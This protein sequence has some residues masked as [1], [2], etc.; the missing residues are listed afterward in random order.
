[1]AAL[2]L[3]RSFWVEMELQ[4]SLGVLRREG[5]P[6]RERARLRAS[7]G[8]LA[9]RGTLNMGCLGHRALAFVERWVTSELA[10]YYDEEE[11][12]WGR[13]QKAPLG[14][15]N[16]WLLGRA[17]LT[18]SKNPEAESR[19]DVPGVALI[20]LAMGALALGIVQ[21]RDWGWTSQ[22]VLGSFA[23]AAASVVMFLW[24]LSAPAVVK[25]TAWFSALAAS[26][27]LLLASVFQ[28][29][30]LKLARIGVLRGFALW[31]GGSPQ[32]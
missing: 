7:A 19:F 18:D 3:D 5:L 21:G 9:R 14:W 23:V 32:K 8:W 15:N 27:T 13:T 11:G 10:D 2:G 22:A 30:A 31:L 24:Q 4:A 20:S 6:S 12:G 25:I 29:V 16:A 1:M 28:S 26:V 17:V